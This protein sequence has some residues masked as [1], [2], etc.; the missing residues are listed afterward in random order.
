VIS[1]FCRGQFGRSEQ[2]DQDKYQP[3][4]SGAL[5]VGGR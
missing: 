1:A 3:H 5:V 4:R 2:E